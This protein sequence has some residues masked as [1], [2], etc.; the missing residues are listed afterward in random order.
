MKKA[1]T[2]VMLIGF[3]GF[4]S[5]SAQTYDNA[6][7]L[8]LGWGF[9]A[10]IKHFFNESHAVEGI[11]RYRNGYLTYNYTQITGLYQ[12]HK[13]L[14]DVASGLQWYFGGGAFLGFFGGDFIENKARIGILG[15]LGLDYAFDGVPINISLDWAPGFALTGFGNAFSAESGGLAVRYI[16]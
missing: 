4:F 12:V 5:A 6:I 7:G 14:D 9:G 2:L 15:N 8:R 1:F 13:P 3:V 16:F 11:F 10:S